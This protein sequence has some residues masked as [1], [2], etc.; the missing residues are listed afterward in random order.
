MS[1][2]C[3]I[4]SRLWFLLSFSTSLVVCQIAQTSCWIEFPFEKPVSQ[5]ECKL[6]W[7]LSSGSQIGNQ[8]MLPP[9]GMCLS[10][11]EVKHFMKTSLS[12]LWKLWQL[13]LPQTLKSAKMGYIWK[14]VSRRLMSHS[15][16]EES[17]VH[18]CRLNAYKVVQY[19]LD[20]LNG[21]WPR[22]QNCYRRWR[23]VELFYPQP[24]HI[25]PQL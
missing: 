6:I 8:C 9:G 2:N 23:N 3:L 14:F 18:Y 5:T 22:E 19:I 25:L 11:S 7:N 24:T 15:L 4:Q 17:N 16:L 13:M 21:K 1:V 10:A 20:K 12:C